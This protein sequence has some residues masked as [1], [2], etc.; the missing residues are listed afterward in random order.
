MVNFPQFHIQRD[1]TVFIFLFHVVDHH[2]DVQ[3]FNNIKKDIQVIGSC[4]T[5]ITKKIHY[6]NPS[7]LKNQR[8]ICALL[9]GAILIDTYNLD[10][11]SGRT[12]EQDIFFAEV[13]SNNGGLD[14]DDLF[15]KLMKGNF[16]YDRKQNS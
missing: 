1:P 7:L 10:L 8:T 4:A 11:H 3:E 2:E 13:L 6:E 16:L 14:T 9:L 12:T 5:L 15:G